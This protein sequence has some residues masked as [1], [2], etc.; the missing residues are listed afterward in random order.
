[1]LAHKAKGQRW[2][3]RENRLENTERH[4]GAYPGMGHHL[5]YIEL[6][7]NDILRNSIR[8][9]GIAFQ[10]P[11]LIMSEDLELEA[12][13]AENLLRSMRR[14]AQPLKPH[15]DKVGRPTKQEWL[16]NG[17]Q[18]TRRE[19]EAL[20]ARDKHRKWGGKRKGAGRPRL[21]GARTVRMDF[22]IPKG[23]RSAF[24]CESLDFYLLVKPAELVKLVPRP[25]ARGRHAHE[26]RKKEGK[27]VTRMNAIERARHKLNLIEAKLAE[28]AAS[29]EKEAVEQATELAACA[30]GQPV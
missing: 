17:C 16:D 30:Q 14:E 28:L 5:N 21:Q 8:H 22:S 19:W 1:M 2:R 29:K 13:Q 18:L 15:Y 7:H 27:R 10:S 4:C 11:E 12:R 9:P 6:R 26:G 3:K 23:A 25:P 24:V 20:W